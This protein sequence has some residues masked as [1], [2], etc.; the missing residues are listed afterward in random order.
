MTTAHEA[1]AA[2]R[3]LAFLDQRDTMRGLDPNDIIG[4]NDVWLTRSDL[5]ILAKAVLR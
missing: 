5:L 2:A 3:V 4:A 1:A